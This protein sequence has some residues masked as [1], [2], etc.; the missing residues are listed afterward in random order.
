MLSVTGIGRTVNELRKFEGPISEKAKVLVTS[1]KAVVK[2]EEDSTP[3]QEG[4]DVE[5]QGAVGEWR[6]NHLSDLY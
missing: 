1:W 6:N 3:L 5:E 4:S 2:A